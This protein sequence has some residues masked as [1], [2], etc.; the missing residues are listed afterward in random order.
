MLPEALSDIV[1][2]PQTIQTG[3]I[4]KML[5][6]DIYMPLRLLVKR[7]EYIE[8]ITLPKKYKR[9]LVQLLNIPADQLEM[10]KIEFKKQSTVHFKTAN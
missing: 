4:K 1:E 8:K 10:L 3:L 5:P 2:N 6:W 9:K 7:N